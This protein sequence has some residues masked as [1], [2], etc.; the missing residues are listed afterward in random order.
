M[1]STGS[2]TF[3]PFPC[4]HYIIPAVIAEKF[5]ENGFKHVITYERALSNKAM[6]SKNSPRNI[7]GKTVNTML[8]EYTAVCEKAKST[9]Y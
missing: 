7:A 4:R 9:I 2:A 6:P 8:F 5:E 3:F 1:K